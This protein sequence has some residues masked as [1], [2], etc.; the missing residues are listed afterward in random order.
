MSTYYY[1]HCEKCR[2]LSGGCFTRQAWGYGNADLIDTFKFVMHHIREC[3][4]QH[5]GMHSEYADDG[6]T[7]TSFD[8]EGGQRRQHL[9]ATADIWPYSNDWGF[10]AEHGHKEIA[11]LK[12]LWVDSEIAELQE[13]ASPGN[14][15]S[16]RL[17][18]E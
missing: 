17:T 5:I 1:F 18:S 7:T 8:T 11:E 10:M 12:R 6:R 13:W 4:E 2:Q 15:E 14:A 3:G 9:E 16:P